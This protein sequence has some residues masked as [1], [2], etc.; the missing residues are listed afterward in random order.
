ML[1][2]NTEVFIKDFSRAVYDNHPQSDSLSKPGNDLY[3]IFCSFTKYKNFNLLQNI[4]SKKN[5]K[6]DFAQFY[7]AL[8]LGLHDELKVSKHATNIALVL[9]RLQ[10]NDKH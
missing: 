4:H 10:L 8:K 3:N 9:A 6:I 1:F 2:K 5:P 7:H